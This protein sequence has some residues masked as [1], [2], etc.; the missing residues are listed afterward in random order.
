MTI[1]ALTPETILRAEPSELDGLAQLREQLDAILS[2]VQTPRLIGPDGDAIDL[3]EAVF[4]A[5]KLIVDA[6]A[7]GQSITLVPHDKELTTQDAADLLHVSRPHLIKLLDT[8]E[9][10][11]H[12]VGTHRRIK[13]EDM[14]AYQQRRDETRGAALDEL[15]RVSEELPSGYR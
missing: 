14:L 10:P 9:L 6:M 8:G 13:I 7:R 3:P 4:E 12:R 15:A 11:F 2:R 5:L 1:T